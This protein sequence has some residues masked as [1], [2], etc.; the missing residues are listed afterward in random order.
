MNFD[1][2]VIQFLQGKRCFEFRARNI[3]Q[4]KYGIG[5]YIPC[6][7]SQLKILM[8]K[9][10]KYHEATN[11]KINRNGINFKLDYKG[12]YESGFIF[13]SWK[14]QSPRNF[15]VSMVER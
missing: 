15:I 8:M 10:R 14:N 12:G 1:A 9:L 7:N 2:D 6:L 4:A 3:V 11:L 5:Q 13:K